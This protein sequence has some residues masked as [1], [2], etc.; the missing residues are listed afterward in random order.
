MGKRKKAK[1]K[2]VILKK[3]IEEKGRDCHK[4]LETRGPGPINKG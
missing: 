2:Q 4:F 3:D 1:K